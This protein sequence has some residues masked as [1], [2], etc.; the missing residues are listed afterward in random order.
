M[1]NIFLDSFQPNLSAK[2]PLTKLILKKTFDKIDHTVLIHNLKT[3]VILNPIFLL[4]GSK[5]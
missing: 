5:L 3:I 2:Y 1:Y 4:I